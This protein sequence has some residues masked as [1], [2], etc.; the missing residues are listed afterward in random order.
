MTLI[1]L[2][3]KSVDIFQFHKN[4]LHFLQ[5]SSLLSP[6]GNMFTSICLLSLISIIRVRW[7]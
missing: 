3:T 5:Q 6:E 1:V 7:N 2:R 4:M